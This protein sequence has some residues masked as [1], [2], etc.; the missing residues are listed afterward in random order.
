MP[1]LRTLL[2]LLAAPLLL[3]QGKPLSPAAAAL[4]DKAFAGLPEQPLVDVHAHLVGLGK[5]GTWVNPEKL[6]LRHPMKRLQTSLYLKASGAKDLARFDETFEATLLARMA[7]FPKGFRLHLFA[8]DH[9]YTEAG[10]VD[11]AHSEIFVPNEAV[12]AF[13]ERHPDCIVPVLSIHPYRAD[14][15]AELERWAA[16]GARYVKWLPN[17][18]NIDPADPRCDAFY[19]RMKEL[20]M[21]LLTHVGE[22]KAVHAEQAQRLGNPLRFRRALDLGLTVIMAHCASLGTN[23]DLDHPGRRAANFDL[24]LRLMEEPTYE[25]RLWG[26]ISAITQIN[27]LEKP[28]LAILHRPELQRRL[29]NGSDYPLP[30][31][32][33]VIWTRRLR[34]LGLLT[35]AERKA[36]NE[37]FKANPLLFDFVL[38]RTLHTPEG[39]RLDPALF[40]ARPELPTGFLT[41]P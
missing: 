39:G 2:L 10:Q 28:L 24:F 13:A 8:F 38:K 36:L 6:T 15:L 31:V 9:A 1:P 14:A 34:E 16:R 37:I 19:Q 32:D 20:G 30:G 5:D 26:D 4:V 41:L 35:R 7:A 18:Q 27:R 11:L 23:E 12:I 40:V 22:E 21:V 17:A 33:L 3:A 29:L 25:G